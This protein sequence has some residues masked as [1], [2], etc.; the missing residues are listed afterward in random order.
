M[1]LR[2]LCDE[3]IDVGLADALEPEFE[4]VRV[5]D[6][7]GLGAAAAD[8]EIWRYADEN[9]YTILTGDEDFVTGAA[10]PESTERSPG[11]IHADQEAPSGDVVRALRAVNRYLSSEEL[12]DETIFVPGNWI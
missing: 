9:G 1:T 2:L 12:T 6:V 7:D 3:N 11:I 8:E 4:T 5:P 10:Q